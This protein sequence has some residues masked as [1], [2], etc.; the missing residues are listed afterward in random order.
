MGETRCFLRTRQAEI[1]KDPRLKHI[2]V[3][4]RFD[5]SALNHVP[6][7]E[8]LAELRLLRDPRGGGVRA[9]ELIRGIEVHPELRTRT[10]CRPELLCRCWGD[11]AL[12]RDDLVYQR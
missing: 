10:K 7:R 1:L 6:N 9:P 11:A 8:L 4:R 3:L 2:G 5:P 12:G